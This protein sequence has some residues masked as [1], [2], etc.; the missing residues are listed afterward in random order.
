LH[1]ALDPPEC[2]GIRPDQARCGVSS[3][4]IQPITTRT[5]RGTLRPCACT[6][7]IGSG[8]QVSMLLAPESGWLNGQR[9][10]VSGGMNL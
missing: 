9:V 2:E 10:E 4:A 7:E 6:S 8:S 3:C 1:H 5:W